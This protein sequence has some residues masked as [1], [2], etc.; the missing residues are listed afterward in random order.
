MRGRRTSAGACPSIWVRWRTSTNCRRVWC[1][2]RSRGRPAAAVLV[3]ALHGCRGNLDAARM[4]ILACRELPE[5]K[6][7]RYTST[8]LAAV[9]KRSRDMLKREMTMEQQDDLWEIERR[10]GTYLLG[11]ETVARHA[12]GLGSSRPRGQFCARAVRDPEPV[13][14]LKMRS[15]WT[16]RR[17][18]SDR[19]A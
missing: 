14:P 17:R 13:I 9:S 7:E 18:R 1:W 2:C 4:G 8:I 12:A 6:R 16:A 11:V 5:P 19:R 3:A 10:S 15:V